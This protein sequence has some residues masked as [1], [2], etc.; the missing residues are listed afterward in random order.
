MRD[1]E[2]HVGQT[3]KWYAIEHSHNDHP[4]I[5]VIMQGTGMDRE[6]R[7]ARPVV[8]HTQDFAYV[9]EQGEAHSEHKLQRFLTETFWELDQ[10]DGISNNIP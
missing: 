1:L 4:H 5:H 9:R 7:C 3:L 10:Y 8:F 6:A 2:N